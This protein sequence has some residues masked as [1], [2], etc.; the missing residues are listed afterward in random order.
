[1]E[2]R[3][4]TSGWSYPSGD[5]TWNGVFYPPRGRG[6]RPRGFDELAFYA[7]HFDT[8]EVNSSFYRPPE[9]R[10]TRRW[11]ERTP[12][13]FLFSLKLHQQF[14]HPKMFHAATGRHTR[15]V[16]QTDVDRFLVGADPLASAGKLGA[17]L[18]QFPPSFKQDDRSLAYLE[19]LLRRLDGWP[20]AVELR[21]R[22]WS[23]RV[24]DTLTRLNQLGAAWV[25]IDEPKFRFSIQQNQ[26]PNVESFYYMRLHGRNAERWW[27]H[28]VA[29]QRY[30]YLY[31]EA[32]LRPFAQTAD[33]A[34]RLV[35]KLY[36]YLNNH[37]AAKAVANAVSLKAMLRQPIPGTYPPAFIERY[38]Q[39]A[40]L[41]RAK[42]P[43]RSTVP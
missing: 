43:D 23:D 25:Q 33:A 7:E 40:N 20:V 8:V 11:V 19:W 10:I 36:L 12:D 16:A 39:V 34:Q 9:A 3:I 14:T 1:M 26:L 2:V 28:D 22:S 32:E 5:G 30:D 31:S 42:T 41:V 15:T 13:H 38:P 24:G 35:K 18:A 21:H 4:G 27:R 6:H 29:E 37:F 17:L